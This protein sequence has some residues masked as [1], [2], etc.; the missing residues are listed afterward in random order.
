MAEETFRSGLLDFSIKLY[1]TY[2]DKGYDNVF[3]SPYSISAALLLA[4]LGANNETE[5]QIRDALGASSIPKADIHV[6]HKQL[7]NSLS[8]ETKGTTKL[9]VANR[10]FTKLGLTV[11]DAYKASSNHY[12]GSDIELLDFV[13]EPEQSRQY[14]NKWVEEQTMG[15]IQDLLP[16]GIIRPDALLVLINAVYFKGKWQHPFDPFF[17]RESSFYVTRNNKVPVNT[18][19]LTETLKYTHDDVAG[20]S[21]VKLQYMNS[22]I[23]MI[24]I[25]PNEKE[26]LTDI[27]KQLNAKFI[28]NVFKALGKVFPVTVRLVI[29]KFKMET[30]YQLEND[31]QRLGIV[32]MFDAHTADFSAMLPKT[33]E[34]FISSA[35]HKAFVAVDEEGTEAAAATDFEP[36]CLGA[37]FRQ[38]KEFIADHPFLFLITEATSNSI[39]FIGRFVR[40]PT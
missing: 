21:A 34:A 35:V 33:T 4:N 31:L 16:A 12:Y 3:F 13:G 9:S 27:E 10:I 17:T 15:K 6:Q 20:Y 28:T 14:I 11:D 36:P 39:L 40:P 24:F 2:A 1:R 23:A 30:Q 37:F 5:K 22:N 19:C 32:D 29:P 18:M 8:A 26:G 7:E 25:L 38:P